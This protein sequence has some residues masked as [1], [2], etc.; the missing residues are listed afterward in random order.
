MQEVLAP[1]VA[2]LNV[3]L[4][5]KLVVFFRS[6]L[7]SPSSEVQVIARLAAR[8]MRSNLGKNLALIREASRLD[9]WEAGIAQLRAVLGQSERREVPEG[10]LWRVGVLQKL[11]GERLLANFAADLEEEKRLEG[12]ISSLVQN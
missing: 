12:F 10:D 11:L 3:S 8:D 7:A 2:D 4:M 9:P 1:H 6:L 5:M